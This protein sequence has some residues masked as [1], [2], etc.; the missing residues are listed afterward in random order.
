LNGLAAKWAAQNP[1]LLPVDPRPIAPPLDQPVVE[2]SLA[3]APVAHLSTPAPI[4]PPLTETASAAPQ[5]EDPW[6]Q[7]IVIS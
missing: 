1:S 5:G 3:T 2:P 6:E 4:P 7:K